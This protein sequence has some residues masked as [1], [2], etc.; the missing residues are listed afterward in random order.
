MVRLR[1]IVEGQ[2]ER[3]FV[4]TVLAPHLMRQAEAFDGPEMID[5]GYDTAPSRRLLRAIP[6]FDKVIGG[7]NVVGRIGI[8]VLKDRCPHF[9][10]WV[11]RLESLGGG[12]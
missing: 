2:T 11:N 4:E 6:E 9:R 8:Q 10:S 1:F 5:G 12:Q 3:R 7:V